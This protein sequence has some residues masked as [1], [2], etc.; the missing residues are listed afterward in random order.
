MSKRMPASVT[1]SCSSSCNDAKGREAAITGPER[2][3]GDLSALEGAS[4]TAGAGVVGDGGVVTTTD[5]IAAGAR[6]SSSMLSIGSSSG[7]PRVGGPDDAI[8]SDNVGDAGGGGTGGVFGA[9]GSECVG[10][11]G[12][13]EVS[14][15]ALEAALAW[16]SSAA[17]LPL[18]MGGP[19]ARRAAG[20]GTN[21]TPG[22]SCW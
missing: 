7:E 16:P 15:G 11:T 1:V 18:A 10:V 17:M 20:G 5:G 12:A 2:G 9:G 19:L 3:E 6:M 22:Y 21:A 13:G 8:Q 4:G 14:A